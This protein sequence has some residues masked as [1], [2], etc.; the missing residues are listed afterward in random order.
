M[1]QLNKYIV[2]LFSFMNTLF[3]DI[4]Y[5]QSSSSFYLTNET[6]I[7]KSPVIISI[8]TIDGLY[9]IDKADL[10]KNM[11]VKKLFKKNK[12]RLLSNDIYHYL[13]PKE[14]NKNPNFNDCLFKKSYNYNERIII[15]EL[16]SN[17]NE[18]RIGLIRIDY[19]NEKV[20]TVDK[21]K[22]LFD[23]KNQYFFCEILFPICN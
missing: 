9:L 7:I 19:Y 14:L 4:T 3:C 17:I 1:G 11:N 2:F 20:L 21:G 18:F 6:V 13:S 12:L 22:T 15:K 5:S 8:V 10:K 16:N 23:D